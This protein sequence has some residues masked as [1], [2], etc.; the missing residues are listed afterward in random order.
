MSIGYQFEIP[1]SDDPYSGYPDDEEAVGEHFV[2][3]VP[4]VG[5]VEE[6]LR[7]PDDEVHVEE[8]VPDTFLVGD[9][10]MKMLS[11]RQGND[12]AAPNVESPFEQGQHDADAQVEGAGRQCQTR[13]TTAH[14]AHGLLVDEHP[15]GKGHLG[16]LFSMQGK[17]GHCLVDILFERYDV[18]ENPSRRGLPFYDIVHL[19]CFLYFIFRIYPFS[20]VVLSF[21]CLS[22]TNS[23]QVEI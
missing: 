1:L 9:A 12:P 2:H 7:N 11:F 17:C 19:F 18:V 8:L 22:N 21:K 5:E 15:I 10:K 14:E 4:R 3:D 16:A 20:L 23:Q 6:K 13:F